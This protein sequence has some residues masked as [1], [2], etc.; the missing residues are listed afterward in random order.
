MS[1]KKILVF[2]VGGSAEP[3]VNAIRNQKHNFIYF[4][5]S[6]GPKGSEMTIDSPGDPCED[7]RSS[8]CPDCG[9]EYHPGDPKGKAIVFQVG[10]KKEHEYKSGE[11]RLEQII[12]RRNIEG[13]SGMVS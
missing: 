8:K 13:A 2:S 1:M 6:S 9:H 3:I 5:C 12:F 4:F 11:L 10:L 7:K